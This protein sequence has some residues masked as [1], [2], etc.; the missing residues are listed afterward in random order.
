MK[1]VLDIPDDVWRLVEYIP[2]DVLPSILLDIIQNDIES[3][4]ACVAD[5]SL[6]ASNSRD[7]GR[8]IDMIQALAENSDRSIKTTNSNNNRKVDSSDSVAAPKV[9]VVADV[10]ADLDLDDDFMDMLK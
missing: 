7:I 2:R 3:R 5:E 9:S 10:S 4:S 1:V 6:R 8:L